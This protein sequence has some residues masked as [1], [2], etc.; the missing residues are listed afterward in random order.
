VKP[1]PSS[2]ASSTPPSETKSSEKTSSRARAGERR[3]CRCAEKES[4]C[5]EGLSPPW[6]KKGNR[7]LSGKR[8]LERTSALGEAAA[9]PK[10]SNPAASLLLDGRTTQQKR[11]RFSP[12][13]GPGAAKGAH[14]RDLEWVAPV[15]SW[16][17]SLPCAR[18]KE[19]LRWAY[20]AHARGTAPTGTTT[21]S[22]HHRAVV[23]WYGGS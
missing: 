18:P 23:P 16:Q 9:A 10:S 2:P 4:L 22:G 12:Q 21:P 3:P 15:P 8:T 17:G 6:L 1:S 14:H 7:G 19:A 13:R 11:A 20:D 5:G